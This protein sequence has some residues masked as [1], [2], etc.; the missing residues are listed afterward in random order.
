[1][2][3]TPYNV[4]ELLNWLFNQSESTKN[5]IL[6]SL[7]TIVGFL[8]AYATATANWKSQMLANLKL[9]AAGDIESFFTECAK[10][11]SN[12]SIYSTALIDAVNKIQKGCS[13]R[14]AEFLANYHRE[15]ACQF[16]KDRDKLIALGV[17][18]HNLSGRYGALLLTAP[19]LKSNF[20]SAINALNRINDTLWISV[21]SYIENDQNPV[22]SF[23]NQVNVPECIEL[24]NAFD[25]NSL[26]LNFA[27]GSVRGNLMS[28][29]VGVNFWTILNIFKERNMF[30]NTIKQR[31]EN[32]R[33]VS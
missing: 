9:Q 15:K 29:I 21:P 5:T 8:L 13:I 25:L 27:S 23:I 3:I 26:E 7:I 12:C 28:T 1:M 6:G 32:N 19:Y 24:K 16:I 11:S 22:Q 18:V 17:D 4:E 2:G 33:K 10:L 30:F 14:D 31:K 20:D